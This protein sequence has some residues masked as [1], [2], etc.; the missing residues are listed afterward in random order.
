MKSSKV[1]LLKELPRLSDD[2]L[3]YQVNGWDTPTHKCKEFIALVRNELPALLEE[4]NELY[5][6]ISW[7]RAYDG[8]L[9]VANA[10]LRG[11]Y[12]QLAQ[13]QAEVARLREAFAMV[14]KIL[15]NSRTAPNVLDTIDWAAQLALT[16]AIEASDDAE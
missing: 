1:E 4:R 12:D 11:L 3:F 13:S 7:D 6:R 14:R 8:S 15:R 5:A 9:V 10:E 2:E 16:P